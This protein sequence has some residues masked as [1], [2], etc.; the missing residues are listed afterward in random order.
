MTWTILVA[1]AGAVVALVQE[2]RRR[3]AL[4]SLAAARRDYV[5][6]EVQA[7]AVDQL[8]EQAEAVVATQRREINRL[9]EDVDA[10]RDPDV[11]RARLVGVLHD[12]WAGDHPAGPLPD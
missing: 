8:R 7:R 1:L 12:P 11:V 4:S 3:S 10:C 5:E 6:M 9:I 2:I